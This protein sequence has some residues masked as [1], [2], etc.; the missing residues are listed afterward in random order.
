MSWSQADLTRRKWKHFWLVKNGPTEK[1]IH[2]RI[3]KQKKWQFFSLNSSSSGF[4]I[5][6]N[7]LHCKLFNII[8]IL[9]KTSGF[10]SKKHESMALKLTYP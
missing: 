8:L 5:L 2:F 4:G 6:L 1:K 3:I 9:Y 10:A 7:L